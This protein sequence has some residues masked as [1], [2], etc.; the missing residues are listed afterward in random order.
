MPSPSKEKPDALLPSFLLVRPGLEANAAFLAAM[1]GDVLSQK[2][3][4]I[5]APPVHER[6]RGDAAQEHHRDDRKRSC[7]D[8]NKVPVRNLQQKQQYH[9]KTKEQN[10]PLFL[11]SLLIF[12]HH[13]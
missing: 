11:P 4:A 12:P 7:A 13:P 1:R 2:R 6:K 5:R 10:N 9:R 8:K 3:V